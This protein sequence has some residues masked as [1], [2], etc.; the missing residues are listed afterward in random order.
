MRSYLMQMNLYEEVK[1]FLLNKLN[2]Q[3]ELQEYNLES[4]DIE[5]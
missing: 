4:S 1:E 3:Y 5:R 2:K